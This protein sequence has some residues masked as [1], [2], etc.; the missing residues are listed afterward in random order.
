MI[1]M[2]AILALALSDSI[3]VKFYNNQNGNAHQFNLR[4]DSQSRYAAGAGNKRAV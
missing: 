4:L 1:R 2:H 3:V